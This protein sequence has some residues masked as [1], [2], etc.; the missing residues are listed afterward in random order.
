MKKLLMYLIVPAVLL[1]ILLT[2]L[3]SAVISN[4]QSTQT[5]ARFTYTDGIVLHSLCATGDFDSEHIVSLYG[6]DDTDFKQF[7]L[8]Q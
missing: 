4:Y 1:V 7:L 6:E 3:I 8:N 5:G 2:L